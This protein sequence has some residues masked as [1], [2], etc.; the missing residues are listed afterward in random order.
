MAA[1]LTFMFSLFWRERIIYLEELIGYPAGTDRLPSPTRINLEEPGKVT[2][3]N[4]DTLAVH[5]LK[6]F[7]SSCA[8]VSVFLLWQEI[9]FCVTYLPPPPK[10]VERYI[11]EYVDCKKGTFF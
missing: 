8:I 11:L 6:D 2:Q 7:F 5:G 3:P 9:V 10:S 1:P 4:Q